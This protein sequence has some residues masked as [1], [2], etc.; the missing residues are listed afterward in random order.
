MRLDRI[1]DHLLNMQRFAA[2]ALA[3]VDG[4]GKE[5]FLGDRQAQQAVIMNLMII[6]EL[7]AKIM[8]ASPAFILR[9]PAL[10][11]KKMRNMRNRIAHDYFELD[12]D[13]VWDTVQRDLPELLELL[14]PVIAAARDLH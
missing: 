1:H 7:T 11:W 12:I 13:I 8:N 6:G 14:P 5:G 3:F 4:C 10:A 2:E 9:H